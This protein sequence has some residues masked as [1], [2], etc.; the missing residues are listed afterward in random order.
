M[1]FTNLKDNIKQL[2]FTKSET[3][4]LYFAGHGHFGSG[5]GYLLTSEAKRSDDGIW[6]T[7]LYTEDVN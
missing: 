6:G 2:F 5:G 7:S 4:L 3:A 1:Q